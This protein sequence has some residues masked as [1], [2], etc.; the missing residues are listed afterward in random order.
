MPAQHLN[1]LVQHGNHQNHRTD[2]ET[3]LWDPNRDGDQIAGDVV[4]LIALQSEAHRPVPQVQN[5]HGGHAQ[6]EQLQHTPRARGDPL[7]HQRH[8]HE[9]PV[10]KTV[11]HAQKGGGGAQPSHHIIDPAHAPVQA[12]SDR[13]ADHQ[14]QNGQDAQGGQ[15]AAQGV[16][17]IQDFAHHLICGCRRRSGLCLRGP[18]C[19]TTP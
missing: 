3:H 13:R 17:A 18:L 12:A 1:T 11:G 9:V 5:G 2:D 4:E 6:R 16:Q 7:Q 8:A 19:P 14:D 10:A 15:Q